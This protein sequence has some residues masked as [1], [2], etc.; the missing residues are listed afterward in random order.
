MVFFDDVIDY[1]PQTMAANPLAPRCIAHVRPLDAAGRP[2]S[3][4]TPSARYNFVTPNQC[5]DMHSDCAPQND[6][7]KQGDDWLA[8]W[9]PI[10]QQ[11][12][13]YQRG[14][15]I[16]ITWDEAGSGARLPRPTARSA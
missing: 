4:Q 3:R 9:I 11:S 7:I 5:N 1:D 6:E 14:G 12:P 2:I 10:I 13:A 16:F 15:A 8:H